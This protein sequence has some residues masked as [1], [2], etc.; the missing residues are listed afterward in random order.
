LTN[1]TQCHVEQ[2]AELLDPFVL[3]RNGFIGLPAPFEGIRAF[4]AAPPVVPHSTLM[5]TECLSCHGPHGPDGMETTHP[6]RQNCLQCHA[7][8]AVLD[9]HP[10]GLDMRMLPG[11]IVRD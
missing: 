7:P 3:A 8:S 6:W 2:Q 11:P 9:Q 5:R 10:S 1:C 4:S